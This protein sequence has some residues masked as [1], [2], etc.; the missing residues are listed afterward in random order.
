MEWNHWLPK[1]CF[2]DIKVGQWLTFRQHSIA[3]ALQTIA[4]KKNCMCGWHKSYLPP[5]LLE[6]AWS[7]F[8]EARRNLHAERDE[9]GR[10]LHNLKL[11][12]K[13]HAAKDENG[14]S[15]H[16]MET[17]VKLHMVKNE[18]GK[19]V[20]SLKVHEAKDELGRSLHMV[21][22]HSKRDELGRS[23]VAMKTNSQKWKCLVTGHISTPGPLTV[24]QKSRNID[25]SLRVKLE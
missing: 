10:S 23:C 24:Y 2:P 12:E 13:L 7:Y 16:A 4:L 11:N 19:S 17:I 18:E 1:A 20:H 9:K 8:R 5:E 25:P 3:S 21:K 14:K 15:I 6:L 22:I